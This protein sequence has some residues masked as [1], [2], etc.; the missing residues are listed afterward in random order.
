LIMEITRARVPMRRKVSRAETALAAR[1]PMRERDFSLIP[2]LEDSNRSWMRDMAASVAIGIPGSP[3]LAEAV[4]RRH[5]VHNTSIY[6]NMVK[7]ESREP[8]WMQL[9]QM[10]DSL[11]STIGEKKI[12]IAYQKRFVGNRG[13]KFQELEP[14]TAD[15]TNL[16]RWEILDW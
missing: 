6:K 9:A 3:W 12:W 8:D 11:F 4:K 7:Y 2:V 10:H 13:Q 16:G 1:I 15:A 5:D 14:N